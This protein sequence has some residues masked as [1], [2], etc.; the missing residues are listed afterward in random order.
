M[1]SLLIT[2]MWISFR[3]LYLNLI[4]RIN[5]SYYLGLAGIE[6][7]LN[8]HSGVA[9]HYNGILSSMK[10]LDDSN[11]VFGFVEESGPFRFFIY[12]FKSKHIFSKKQKIW[13]YIIF[14]ENGT[15]CFVRNIFYASFFCEL[16]AIGLLF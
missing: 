16:L 2:E 3:E 9:F 14:F 10:A 13:L 5:R 7:L 11:K 8:N 1:K 12:F 15:S 4:F 6:W